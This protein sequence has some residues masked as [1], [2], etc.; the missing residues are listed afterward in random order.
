MTDQE[1][2]NQ[3]FHRLCN[4]KFLKNDDERIIGKA[5]DVIENLQEQIRYVK[6][7]DND[8]D[9]EEREFIVSEANELIKE[10]QET[11]NNQN[12]V[13]SISFNPMAGFYMLESTKSLLDDLVDY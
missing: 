6:N 12:D 7:P 4:E 1:L 11:Y 13:I 3:H 8:I 10:I 2:I 9:E 5:K